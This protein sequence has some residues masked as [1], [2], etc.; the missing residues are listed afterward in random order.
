MKKTAQGK[1]LRRCSFT[2]FINGDD[3]LPSEGLVRITMTENSRFKILHLWA[4]EAE[5]GVCKD[6]CEAVKTLRIS[7]KNWSQQLQKAVNK[8]VKMRNLQRL[9]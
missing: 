3:P 2:G 9:D 4:K 6:V 8:M 1:L 5:D 7:I